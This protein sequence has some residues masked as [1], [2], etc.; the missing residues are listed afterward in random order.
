MA[1]TGLREA[2]C[3]H[4]KKSIPNTILVEEAVKGLILALEQS[5]LFDQ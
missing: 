4:P 1:A 2:I 3:D 5:I